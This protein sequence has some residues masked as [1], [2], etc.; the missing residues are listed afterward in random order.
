MKD[1][2]LEAFHEIVESGTR[3]L[4]RSKVYEVIAK[5]SPICDQ[6]IADKLG[7]GVNRITPRRGELCSLG[8]VYDAGYAKNASGRNVHVWGVKEQLRLI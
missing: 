5:N 6:E 2:S 3:E 4:S 8:L 1:T 7:W